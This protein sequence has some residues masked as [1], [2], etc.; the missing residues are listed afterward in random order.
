[1]MRKLRQNLVIIHIIPSFTS[2]QE[3]KPKFIGI[4]RGIT[5]GKQCRGNR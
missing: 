4:L 1:M 2:A 5:Q 3:I